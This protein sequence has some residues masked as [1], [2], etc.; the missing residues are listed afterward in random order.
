MVAAP[1]RVGD[2]PSDVAQLLVAQDLDGAV[3]DL[4]GVV[5]RDLVSVRFSVSPRACG[6]RI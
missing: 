3:V 6:S 4:E 1:H 5:E 2:V